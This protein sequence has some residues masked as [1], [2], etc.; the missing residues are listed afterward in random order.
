MTSK[1]NGLTLG[2]VAMALLLGPVMAAHGIAF[3]TTGRPKYG[4]IML[5]SEA[6]LIQIMKLNRELVPARLQG[7]KHAQGPRGPGTARRRRP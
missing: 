2:A 6:K 3:S 4:R 5:V 1:V 7:P